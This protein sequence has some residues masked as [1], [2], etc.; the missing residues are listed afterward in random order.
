VKDFEQ[1]RWMLWWDGKGGMSWAW[2]LYP[3]DEAHTRLITRVRLYY[4]WR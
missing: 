3:V 4:D 2:S 1:E